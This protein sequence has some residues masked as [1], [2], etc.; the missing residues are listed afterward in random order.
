MI[1]QTEY[2]MVDAITKVI[3]YINSDGDIVEDSPI[4]FILITDESDLTD[5]SGYPIG[6]I[7]F[8]AGELGKWQ[9]DASGDWISFTPED[10][11]DDSGDGGDDSGDG[12]DDSGDGGGA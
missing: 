1:Y 8:T 11:S 4:K 6:S 10:S 5:L 2:G 7:A 9:L 12:G 3:D